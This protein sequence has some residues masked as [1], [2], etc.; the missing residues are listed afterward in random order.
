MLGG[1]KMKETIKKESVESN[2]LVVPA[3]THKY[4]DEEKQE[5][6]DEI[7]TIRINKQERELLNY[8]KN[9]LH[10]TAD[11]KAIKASMLV[12]RNVIHNTLGEDL[13][14]NLTR[15]DRVK[16]TGNTSKS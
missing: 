2:N 11:S 6:G 14:F 3:F 5:T 12:M 13:T 16:S 1:K 7:L 10:F 4:L 9:N 15:S 8:L